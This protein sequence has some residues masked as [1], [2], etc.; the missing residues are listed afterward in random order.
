[1]ADERQSTKG[2]GASPNGGNGKVYR[3]IR[4]GR[5]VSQAER[6]AAARARIVADD[7]RGLETE[8]WI[9]ELSKQRA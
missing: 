4:T 7:I 5:I 2:A 3:S 1:M 6:I 8:P 9:V